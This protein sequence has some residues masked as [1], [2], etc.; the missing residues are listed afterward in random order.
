VLEKK[1]YMK[2]L[3]ISPLLWAP[4]SG[5]IKGRVCLHLSKR[6]LTFESVISS[7]DDIIS[8][9]RDPLRPLPLLPDL[10]EMA[11]QQRD[12]YP[13]EPLG[14]ATIDISDGYHQFAQTAGSVGQAACHADHDS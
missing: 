12:L 11:C 9:M 4:K 7:V 8:D 10:A 14:G 2:D 6:S 3:H 13:D 1:D 5:K